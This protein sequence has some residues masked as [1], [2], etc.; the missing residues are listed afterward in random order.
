MTEV[1]ESTD[2]GT[3]GMNAV[4]ERIPR[5]AISASH[6][7]F[8]ITKPLPIVRVHSY[9]IE[10]RVLERRPSRSARVPARRV[11]APLSLR[12]TVLALLCMLFATASGVVAQRVQPKWFMSLEN[13]VHPGLPTIS[14]Q[15]SQLLDRAV[16]VSSTSAAITYAV[17]ATSYSIVISVDHPCWFEVKSPAGDST[18]LEAL[19]MS[20]TASPMSIPVHGS[21][22]IWVA[23]QARA[24]TV[25]EGSKVLGTIKAPRVGVLYSFIPK[26]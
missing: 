5:V 1:S 20:P 7:D 6:E 22:S 12:L 18:T 14:T 9:E 13:Y 4:T 3:T 24:I 15:H 17:P 11:P 10:R 8:L 26:P 23:A 19:T 25:T 21:S 16:L 2:A